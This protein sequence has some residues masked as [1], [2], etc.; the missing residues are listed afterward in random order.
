[1]RSDR[2]LPHATSREPGAWRVREGKKEDF[3][4]M[5]NDTGKLLLDGDNRQFKKHGLDRRGLSIE[6]DGEP[7]RDDR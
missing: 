6:Q 3:A 7:I 1:M 5:Q 2:V 4:A